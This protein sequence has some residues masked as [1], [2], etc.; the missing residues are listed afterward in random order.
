MAMIGYG[1]Y[2]DASFD[3]GVQQDIVIPRSIEP[4]AAEF[5]SAGKGT[6][7]ATIPAPADGDLRLI[8]QQFDSD[9]NLHRTMG[10]DTSMGKVFQIRAEQA[11]KQIPIHEEYNRVI[12]SGLSWAA[13]EIRQ[14]D[15]HAGAPLMLTF[16]STEKEPVTLKG[17]L[18]LVR[19]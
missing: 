19:Y 12:W 8:F 7:Q 9:G 16:V 3:F 10:G 1:R 5:Q 13:G 17:Q 18:Y 14:A 4:V 2:A 6:I 11:G 15:M